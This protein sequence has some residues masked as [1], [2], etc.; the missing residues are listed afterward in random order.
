MVLRSICATFVKNA[1][2]LRAFRSKLR[3]GASLQVIVYGYIRAE[4]GSRGVQT[5]WRRT[6]S[7]PRTQEGIQSVQR[8]V[9]TLIERADAYNMKVLQH[10]KTFRWSRHTLLR[11]PAS[12]LI[13]M[14]VHVVSDFT[15]C[16]GVSNLDSPNKGATKLDEVWNE[17]GFWRT[18]ELGSP[19]GAINLARFLCCSLSWHQEAY[20]EVSYERPKSQNLLEKGSYSC[21]CSKTM[22]GQ[23]K[24]IQIQIWTNNTKKVAA[25]A[26]NVRIRTLVFPWAC[27]R[28]DAVERESQRSTKNIEYCRIAVGWLCSTTLNGQRR[29]IQTSVLHNAKEVAAF[30]TQFKPWHW[31]FLET[32]SEN[33]SDVSSD[34]GIIA[35]TVEERMNK[36]NTPKVHSRTRRCS[37]IPFCRQSTKYFQSHLPVVW[38]RNFGTHTL[39]SEEEEEVIEIDP[40]QLTIIT[41]KKR[42]EHVTSSRRLDAETH[43]E[44]R[45]ADSQGFRK[46]R[47][48]QNV[49]I[50]QFLHHGWICYGWKQFYSF[51]QRILRAQ[52]FLKF[53]N[54]SNCQRSREDRTSN[55]NRSIPNMQELWRLSYKYCHDNKEMWSLGCVSHEELNSTH[56]IFSKR[57]WPPK[58]WSRAFASV[59]ET[60]AIASTDTSWTATGKVQSCAKAKDCIDWVRS[61]K[62]G[63]RISSRAKHKNGL[64][65][66]IHFKTIQVRHG[67]C[68]EARWTHVFDTHGTCWATSNFEHGRM[69][70]RTQS[71][72]RQTQHGLLRGRT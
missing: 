61:K 27:V 10:W 41:Q 35:W 22:N 48:S 13:R 54:A 11:D 3:F 51:M 31:C 65:I 72:Y 53:K 2:E 21:Q 32:A 42:A 58:F 30:A 7:F 18:I 25:F 49:E 64:R 46:D 24:V 14:N 50:G 45:N 1:I 16:V 29:A 44:S 33:T 63:K 8:L 6:K 67:G 70:W 43:C 20:S 55:R 40:E 4:Q 60:R 23:R 34:R 36:F 19:R 59:F 69:D 47:M 17:H 68:H 56:D 37:A 62:V 38:D 12:K 9:L 26:G 5:E 57:Y 28:E 71:F 39:K 66:Q 52:E 15:S